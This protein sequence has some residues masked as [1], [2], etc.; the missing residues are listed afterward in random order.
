MRAI[1]DVIL[2]G[3]CLAA[4]VA[5][6]S[7]R[8]E[9]K[10]G[11]GSVEVDA[12]D[13]DPRSPPLLIDIPQ[14]TGGS[15]Q[16]DAGVENPGSTSLRDG[17]VPADVEGKFAKA[18]PV[19]GGVELL[20][21]TA[22]TMF[23]PD[24]GRLLFQWKATAGSVFRLQFE[25]RSNTF[26]VY[27]DGADDICER[28]GLGAKCWESSRADLQ[29]H[30][31]FEAGTSFKLRVSALDP[32]SPTTL[33]Q[34]PEY[35]FHVAREP[36]LG[37][38]YYWSTT[39]KGVRR[40]TLDGR[41]ASDYLTPSTGLT[42]EQAAGL[43][44]AE[45][46]QRC[47]ACHTL[48]RSGKKLMVSLP[49]DQLGIVRVTEDVP[50]PFS[51]ASQSSGVWGSD[52]VVGASWATFSPDETKVITASEG[53]LTLRDVSVERTAPRLLDIPLSSEAGV[54]YFGSMPDW[55]PDGRHIVFTA[56]RAGLPNAN[57][58]RHLHGSAVA[59]MSVNGTNFSDFELAADSR[60]VL[61]NDCMIDPALGRESFANPMFS[62]DSK[63]LL[64]SRADC[65]SERDPSA[66]IV[67]APAAADAPLH[68]LVRANRHVGG[69]TLSNLTNGMPTWGP[70]LSGNIAWIA[71]TSTRDY[72]LVIAPGS[73]LV[74]QVGWPVRQLW[75]AA[76]DVGK[77]GTTEES[78]PA[79]RLPSQ[80]HDENNHRPFWTVDVLPPE[81][82]PRDD[83]PIR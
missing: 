10:R 7:A 67:L 75:I 17:A 9:L 72:G 6:C 32:L 35:V 37:V 78:Y 30:F 58:P 44:L 19:N 81:T 21:P 59:M 55:A 47:V 46:D 31:L 39:A 68:Y 51:Y 34:S 41:S 3:T 61:R 62:P 74:E 50:P 2:K 36:A 66:E 83:P 43:S 73:A 71:F 52:P 27:T 24:L 57:L 20:Y 26:D 14:A 33:R 28:A 76:V 60:G 4:I 11:E 48:S 70:R 56:T 22:E 29:R 25:F 63:W 82:P 49:G 69:R 54:Q 15:P 42:P 38:I 79:F 65:E 23:P 40:G 5:A 77:L 18:T 16:R 45:Q 80:D 1:R 12:S 8:Q 13:A 53:R 64:F